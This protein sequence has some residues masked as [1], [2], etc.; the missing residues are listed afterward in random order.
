MSE[1]PNIVILFTDDQRFD[2]IAALGNRQIHTPNLDR[3]VAEGTT[4]THAHIPSGTSGAVCMPSRAMLHTG[5]TLFHLAGAGGS[6]PT[7]HVLLGETLQSSGYATFGTGKWHNGPASYARSFTA[8]GEVMFGGMADHW[9]TPMC[10]FDPTGRYDNQH[11]YLMDPFQSNTV[12]RWHVDHIHFGRHSTDIVADRTVE[13]LRE[14][15]GGPW[16]TYTAFLAPHDP[17]TMPQRYLDLYDPA[18]IDVPVSFRPEHEFDYGQRF[19]RDET[20]APYPRTEGEVR[21]H[22]AEYYAMITHLDDA[23]GRILAAVEERGEYE[24]TIFVLAGDNG[25]AVGRHGLF[26]KQNHYEHSLRV[27]LIFAGPGI[28]ANRR[29]SSYAYLLDIYPTLCDLVGIDPPSSVEGVSLLPAIRDPSV[30][31]R[32]DLFF[33]YTDLIRSAKDDRYKLILYACQGDGAAPESGAPANGERDCARNR[34]Q[35]FD[36]DRDPDEL[37]NLLGPG[38]DVRAVASRLLAVIE[39]YADEWDDRSSEWGRRFWA[40]WEENGGLG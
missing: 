11:P 15:R 5:R 14:H 7:R 23:I 40:R 1:R 35:L 31:A 25:L 26:G 13:F 8:G 22:T 21:R 24:N 37:V 33:A 12:V 28:P 27:P 16:M 38:A 10:D 2:T 32:D 20:L 9:N 18:K 6:I 39:R 19:I 29:T 36:L 34:A 30:R 17:R 3:L 4:F